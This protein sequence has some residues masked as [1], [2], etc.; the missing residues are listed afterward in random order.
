MRRIAGR[1]GL[2]DE[3]GGDLAMVAYDRAVDGA[4]PTAA[5]EARAWILEY[6]EDDVR[7]TAALREWLDRTANELPSIAEAGPGE[8]SGRG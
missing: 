3:V 2:H 6:N 8:R 5:V 4:D 1:L 7:A